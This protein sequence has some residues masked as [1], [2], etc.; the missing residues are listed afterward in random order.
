MMLY[1]MS[2]VLMAEKADCDLNLHV[3]LNGSCVY[4]ARGKMGS[5]LVVLHAYVFFEVKC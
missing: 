3:R 4:Y 5:V 1:N 2:C